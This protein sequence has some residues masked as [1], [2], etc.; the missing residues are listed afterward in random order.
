MTAMAR[1]AGRRRMMRFR[2]GL[3]LPVLVFSTAAAVRPSPLEAE[4]R[5]AREANL[6]E[7]SRA[8]AAIVEAALLRAGSSNDD[9]AYALRIYRA[10]LQAQM[11][12]PGEALPVLQT[13]LPPHLRK[14]EIEIRRLTALAMAT[15][16]SNNA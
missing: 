13:P 5:K 15:H 16:F 14:T 11:K 8:A 9:W 1:R 12:N 7:G 2:F 6:R 3:L 10:E 4:Y